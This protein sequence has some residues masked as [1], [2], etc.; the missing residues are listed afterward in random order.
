MPSDLPP[1][2]SKACWR[3][4]HWGGMVVEVHASCTRE[5]GCLQASPM[6]GCVYWRAGAGDAHP[7]NWLPEGF[8]T[9]PGVMTWARER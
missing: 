1:D 2:L 9:R 3:C 7:A 6:T 5:D 8:T 4:Q